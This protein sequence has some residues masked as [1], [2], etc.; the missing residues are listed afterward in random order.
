MCINKEEVKNYASVFS[1]TKTDVCAVVSLNNK[2]Y[3]VVRNT[4][5]SPASCVILFLLIKQ[6][7]FHFIHFLKV[8]I[9]S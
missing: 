3:S 7:K 1:E 5:H 4:Y 8:V 2:I 6:R 9:M